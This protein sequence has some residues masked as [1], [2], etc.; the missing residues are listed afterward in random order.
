MSVPWSYYD[1]EE[2]EKIDAL[3]LPRFGEGENMATQ[4]NVAVN[5]LI[6]KWYNDGDVYDNTHRLKGWCNDLSSFANWL[7][8][9]AE[10]DVLLNI[11]DAKNDSDYEDILKELCDSLISL[12]LLEEYA[13]VPKKG[14][15]YDCRGPFKFEDNEEDDYFDYEE[16]E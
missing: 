13:K 1:K 4:I 8:R 6:Y 12:P 15:V 10:A 16:E 2:F 14:S 3:Y 7:F 9:Y 5:K 11:E